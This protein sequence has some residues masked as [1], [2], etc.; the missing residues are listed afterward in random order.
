MNKLPCF[1]HNHPATAGHSTRRRLFGHFSCFSTFEKT[2]SQ[3][4]FANLPRGKA[5]L[6]LHVHM[7]GPTIEEI[8]SSDD[9]D[10][11][12]TA[13][14]E[15]SSST[16]RVEEPDA[17]AEAPPQQR[18]RTRVNEPRRSLQQRRRRAPFADFFGG[19][20][21]G[22]DPFGMLGGFDDFG[23]ALLSSSSSS[24]QQSF[25]T[26]TSMTV[27]ADGRP[28]VRETT[29]TSTRHGRGGAAVVAEQQRTE[30]DSGTGLERIELRRGIGD[31]WR[32]VEQSRVAG[33]P[34]RSRETLHNVRPEE[35]AQ[36]DAQ[37]QAAAAAV[38]GRGGGGTVAALPEPPGQRPQ[39]AQSP[40]K[41]R[42]LPDFSESPAADQ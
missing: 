35:A 13:P 24:F 18:R 22:F 42:K 11:V 36:F 20:F 12:E 1:V 34:T 33:G 38:G 27:G 5:K 10:V 37:W 16:P 23:G 2:L 40:S 28:R 19:V 4:R 3:K 17:A 30:R 6:Y 25:A 39:R 41:R 7:Q 32:H 29:T 15:R 21:G 26:A 31:S 14:P 8:N 9:D